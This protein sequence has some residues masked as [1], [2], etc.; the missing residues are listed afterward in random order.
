MGII[1]Q[2]FSIL[3]II[4]VFILYI[5]NNRKSEIPFFPIPPTLYMAIALF[6]LYSLAV[7]KTQEFF[8]SLAITIC[9]FGLYFLL[10]KSKIV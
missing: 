3:C 5:R 10:K 7:S 1:I 9:S 4:G 2:F 6:T 8:V